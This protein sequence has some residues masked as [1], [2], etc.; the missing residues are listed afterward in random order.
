MVKNIRA[1]IDED[2]Y[3]KMNFVKG[4]KT[5]IDVL[6]RGIESLEAYPENEGWK[7]QIMNKTGMEAKP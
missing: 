4:S 5:W 2:E 7:K 1:T 3:K 6:R